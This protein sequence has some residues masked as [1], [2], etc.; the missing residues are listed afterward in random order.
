MGHD[1]EITM[2]IQ[3]LF[4]DM[5][6]TIFAKQQVQLRPGEPSHHHSLWSRLMAEL[7]P[8]ALEDDAKTI[9]KWEAG[10]YK[11]YLEWRDESVR[12]FQK[13]GLTKALFQQTIE[14]MP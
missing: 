9:L 5:E 13:H 11:S 8:R 4:L 14:S 3:L 2:S 10:A 1:E 6:G 12:I 7:G